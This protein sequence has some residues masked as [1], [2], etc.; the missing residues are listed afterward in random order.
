M[1]VE[2]GPRV[3]PDVSR[4]PEYAHNAAARGLSVASYVGIPLFNADQTLFGTV[5]GIDMSVRD[6]AFADLTP[7]LE[8][9]GQLLSAVR[10]LDGRAIALSRQ[11]EATL[12]EAETDPLTGVRNRRAWQ[13]AC[14]LEEARHHRFGDHAS[15][16]VLDLDGPERI[17]ERVNDREGH[18]GDAVLRRV[19]EVLQSSTRL[20]DV[21]ARL[22]GDELAVLCPQ[23]TEAEVRPLVDR[24]RTLLATEGVSAAIG[25]ATLGQTGTMA[26]AEA[27]AEAALHLD[28]RRRRD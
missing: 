3:A 9:L 28:R 7:Q 20:T 10:A 22:G 5:C 18:A 15:I 21:V 12:R 1:W 24:L 2:G 14:E 11:L 27:A 16:V 17:N 13:R 4:V 25:A 23:T 6:D 26:A 8:L 19:A